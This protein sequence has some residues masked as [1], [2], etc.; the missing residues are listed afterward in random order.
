VSAAM[1]LAKVCR[2][3]AGTAAVVFGLALL[4]GCTPDPYSEDLRYPLRTDPI[5]LKSE[6]DNILEPTPLGQMDEHLAMLKQLSEGE[7]TKDKFSVVDP[8]ELPADVREELREALENVFGTP[9]APTVTSTDEDT[10]KSI[11][12]LQLSD[13][14]LAHGSTIYRRRCVHCHGLTGDGRGPTAPWVNP[15]PRDYRRGVFKFMSVDILAGRGINKPRRG[16]LFYTLRKGIEGTS[17]PAHPDLPEEDLNALISYVIHLSIRGQVEIQVMQKLA[18]DSA[19]GLSPDA[20]TVATSE[21]VRDWANAQADSAKIK[22]GEYPYKERLAEVPP[23]S[24]AGGKHEL[25]GSIKR[26]HQL[27]LEGGCVK[28]HPNYGRQANYMYDAWGTLNR[29]RDLTQG[30]YRGGRRPVDLYYRLHS[31]IMAGGGHS[32][33]MPGAPFR[34][35]PQKM[36]D[37]VNFVKALPYPEMLPEEVRQAVYGERI[38]QGKAK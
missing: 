2:R 27:F 8:A 23:A 35:E 33:N 28:C 14:Q 5:V 12:E 25:S 30:V 17:M 9:A 18:R 32:G 29:P 16:D 6:G 4:S 38:V 26:G 24:I 7:T 19:S 21:I 36:W 15:H 3:L 1:Y 11:E 22:P 20:V 13:K 37:A 31:G 34:T 10:A